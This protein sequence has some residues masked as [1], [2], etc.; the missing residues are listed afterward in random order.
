MRQYELVTI[1]SAEDELYKQGK[2]SVQ[3]EL[4]KHGAV[5]HKEDDMNVR[6]L[7]YPIKK[8]QK[9]HYHLFTL[10]L[11]PE[12]IVTIEKDLKLNSK[13]LKFLFVRKEE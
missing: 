8:Q 9:G 6:Q 2:E 10:E 1:L 13:I 7:A 4:A 5:V 3:E 11:S 12:K